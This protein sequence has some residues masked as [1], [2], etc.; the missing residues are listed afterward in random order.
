M[1]ST[2][3]GQENVLAARVREIARLQKGDW[4]MTHHF[5]YGE[6]TLNPLSG[7]DFNVQQQPDVNLNSSPPTALLAS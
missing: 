4:K 7:V 6:T 2:V 5:Y 1:I 3:H